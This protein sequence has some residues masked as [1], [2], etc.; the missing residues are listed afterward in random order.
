[1]ALVAVKQGRHQDFER[2][3]VFSKISK[4]LLQLQGIPK[5]AS[6]E[7][8]PKLWPWIGYLNRDVVTEWSEFTNHPVCMCGILE[9]C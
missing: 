2:G 4:I 6:N 5:S 3:V 9:F 1:L 7:F 8:L